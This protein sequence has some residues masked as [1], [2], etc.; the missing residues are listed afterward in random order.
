MDGTGRRAASSDQI[1]ALTDTN[2]VLQANNARLETENTDLRET[3][4]RQEQKIKSLQVGV[5]ILLAT[6][7]GLGMG[8]GTRLAGATVSIALSSAAA[9][10]FGVITASLAILN[11]MRK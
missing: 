4:D 5:T 1:K 3:R 8:L 9:V 10:V 11:F 7:A 2:S 6:S